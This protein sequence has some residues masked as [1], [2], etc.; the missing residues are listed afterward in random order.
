MTPDTTRTNFEEGTR[1]PYLTASTKCVTETK[2]PRPRH[3]VTATSKAFQYSALQDNQIRVLRI[4]IDLDTNFLICDFDIRDLSDCQ[5]TYK[6]ISYCWGDPKPTCSVLC[7]TG[8][9]LNLTESAAEILRYV[10]ARNPEDWFWID[11]LCINQSNL[12]ERSA[13]VSIMGPIYS[14]T[15]QVDLS[16]HKFALLYHS[17]NT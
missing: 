10:S 16:P 5:G 2:A 9:Y 12:A 15:K 17:S 13:Q 11:Q 14:S 8:D 1:L 6:A 7:G 4:S 3:K